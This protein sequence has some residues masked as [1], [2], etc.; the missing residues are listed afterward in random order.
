MWDFEIQ[1]LIFGNHFW[2]WDFGILFVTSDCGFLDF[3]FWIFGF[4]FWIRILDLGVWIEVFGIGAF[5]FH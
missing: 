5:D 2:I 4:G 1:I 3:Q